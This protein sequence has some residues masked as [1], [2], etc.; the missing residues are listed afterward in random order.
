MDLEVNP[1]KTGAG[2]FRRDPKPNRPNSA[3]TNKYYR[4]LN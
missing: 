2:W 4:G 1:L 3:L